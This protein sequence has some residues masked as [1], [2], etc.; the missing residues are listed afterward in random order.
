M[1]TLQQLSSSQSS[2]EFPINENSETLSA[3]AIYGKRHPVTTGLTWGYYG[4]LY[5]GNTVA[6]GTVTLTN[7]ADNYVVV[8]RSSG[9]V[10]TS[11]TSVNSLNTAYAKLYK[12]TTLS[13]VVTVAVDQRMDAN[14][15]LL[16]GGGGAGAGTVTNTGGVLTSNA[17]VL[18]AGNADTKAVAGVSTD[19]VS[20]LNLG[21]AGASVGKVVLANATSGT[22]TIQPPTGALGT[23]TLTAPAVSDT[24][25]GKATT[26]TLTNKTINGGAH[27]AITSFGIRSTGAAFDLTMAS[28]EALTAGRTLS[29]NLADAARSITLA[30]NLNLAGNLTTAGAFASTF[31]MTAATVLTFPTTGTLATLAGA[32]AFT[33]KSYNGNTF[34]AG[35]GTLTIAAGKTLTT[36]NSITFVGADAT[37][38]TF[39]PASADIGY[40]GLPLN[41]QSSAYTTVLTDRGKCLYHP[42]TDPTA[43][44]WT[45]D[46]NA[47]VA[48]PIGTTLTFDNDAGAGIITIAITTDTLVLVGSAGSTGSRTLAAGGRA[49]A[50]KVTATRWRIS[51]SAE[52]S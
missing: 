12:L 7:N 41:S 20:A 3:A 25:V 29:W 8:L 26:D 11:T 24:L 52:L 38:M 14:G 23:V 13:G 1:T 27:T 32:E 39:P 43:R 40:L 6:D 36:S 48:Y 19:G 18:G 22:V 10:S 35:T 49:T 16:S 30:G 2:P 37:T 45:I 9:A 50:L 17:V 15:V 46:S 31:T 42:V 33:N 4:G 28:S 34:T 44:I 5:A 47:N 51:G 21:V